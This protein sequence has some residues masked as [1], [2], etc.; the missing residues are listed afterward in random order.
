MSPFIFIQAIA[1]F[2]ISLV[3]FKKIVFVVMQFFA[4]YVLC[5]FCFWSESCVCDL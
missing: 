1:C 4:W 5:W 2:D 3:H